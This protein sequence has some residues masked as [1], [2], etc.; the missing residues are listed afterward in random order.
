MIRYEI[1][2]DSQGLESTLSLQVTSSLLSNVDVQTQ[3]WSAS[4][5]MQEHERLEKSWDP[6]TISAQRIRMRK[7]CCGL[8][9]PVPSG[10]RGYRFLILNEGLRNF[11]RVGA[12]KPTTELLMAM[13]DGAEKNE[14]EEWLQMAQNKS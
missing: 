1:V 12:Q 7:F 13:A 3:V 4:V 8:F 6:E 2:I 14:V 11:K 9:S 10:L 5:K